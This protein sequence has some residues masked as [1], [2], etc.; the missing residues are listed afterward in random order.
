MFEWVL[1]PLMTQEEEK[2]IN[3]IK[4]SGKIILLF[5]IDEKLKQ[6]PASVVSEKIKQAESYLEKIK[7]EIEKIKPEALVN[8]YLEW[9]RWDEKITSIAKI[10]AVKNI[11]IKKNEQA[12]LI[13]PKLK[14]NGLRITV[15]K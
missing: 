14:A 2:L 15:I 5:V 10:E 8:D 13:T 4:D 3:E 6:E 7:K 1:V 9:G 11:L 12:E